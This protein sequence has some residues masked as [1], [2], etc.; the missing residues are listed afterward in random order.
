MKQINSLNNGTSFDTGRFN[1]QIYYALTAN[2]EQQEQCIKDTLFKS[3]FTENSWKEFKSGSTSLSFEDL[4]LVIETLDKKGFKINQKAISDQNIKSPLLQSSFYNSLQKDFEDI[5]SLKAQ[6]ELLQEQVKSEH[7]FFKTLFNVFSNQNPVE[8]IISDLSEFEKYCR[9]NNIT[10]NEANQQLEIFS[11]PPSALSKLKDF[12]FLVAAVG[13]GL[14]G[15]GAHASGIDLTSYAPP[16]NQLPGMF[17]SALPY[18]ALPFVSLSIFRAFSK[19][20]ITEEAGTFGRFA[21]IMGVGVLI[22]LGVTSAMS[23]FLP[24]FEGVGEAYDLA[25]GDQPFSP[26]QYILH[27]IALFAGFA[28][29]YKK[30]KDLDKKVARKETN[31]IKRLFNK[32][33]GLFINDKTAPAIKKAG[34][35]T[36]K[37]GDVVDKSFH[38]FMNVIG[39]PAIFVMMSSLINKGGFNE[40]ANYG[41][42]Y[43]TVTASMTACAF[44]L[45]GAAFAYGCR[46]KEFTEIAKTAST[47]FSISSSA[48]TMPVTKESL[49]NMGV[50]EATRNAVVP[51]GANFNMMGT[52]LYLGVTAASAAVMFGM[53]P[54]LL[55]MATIMGMSVATAFGAPGAPASTILFLDPVLQKAGFSPAQAA[56]VYEMVIPADRLFDM[57]QTSLNVTGDMMVSLDAERAKKK[58]EAKKQNKNNSPKP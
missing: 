58:K 7:G 44:A 38:S 8:K 50:S 39:V 25:Q 15:L 30:A 5:E 17:F 56:K 55:Q 41:S 1:R 13:G 42:Y 20:S 26:S 52:S 6:F 23:G 36:E 27:G 43:L 14:L 40:L 21:G 51:L 24:S 46:K 2:D 37:T 9:E 10:F 11:P 33:S 12:R 47:A 49:K 22:G 19:K 53:E 31:G 54:T 18:F 4:I 57:A 34:R 3:G 48:A 45:A 32:A 28:S 35:F 29:I 16:A